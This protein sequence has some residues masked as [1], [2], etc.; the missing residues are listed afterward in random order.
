MDFNDEYSR[1]N[2]L[3]L[4]PTDAGAFAKISSVFE[5]LSVMRKQSRSCDHVSSVQGG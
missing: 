4:F 3:S 5:K 1:K 2:L